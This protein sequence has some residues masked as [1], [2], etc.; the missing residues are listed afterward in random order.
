MSHCLY[1]AV[2]AAKAAAKY[3]EGVAAQCLTS[4]ARAKVLAAADRARAAALAMELDACNLE[5]GE[6]EYLARE[7]AQ[8]DPRDP[9]ACV[10]R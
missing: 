8:R 3:W 4:G 1:E 2:A 10:S 9:W 5:L 7:A 6:A